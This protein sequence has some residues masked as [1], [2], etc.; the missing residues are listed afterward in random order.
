MD[1]NHDF[2]ATQALAGNFT[3]WD[4]ETLDPLGFSIPG[5]NQ[6]T[7]QD[8]FVLSL[9]ELNRFTINSVNHPHNNFGRQARRDD[10]HNITGNYWLR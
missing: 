4:P 9:S 8:L 5:A 6:A 7:P 10:N 3:G 1:L 2:R